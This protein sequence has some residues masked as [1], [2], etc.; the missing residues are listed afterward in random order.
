MS[1]DVLPPLREDLSLLR[2][3]VSD[4]APTWTLYDPARHRFIRMNWQDFEIFS[5]WALRTPA[6]ILAALQRETTL[7]LREVDVLRLAVFAREAGLLRAATP[8][9]SANLVAARTAAKRSAAAWL[10]HNYL[11]L[12]IRL[13]N[14][15]RFLTAMMP[16]VRWMYTAAYLVALGFLALFGLFLIS[17]QWDLYTHSLVE[18][19]TLDGLLWMGVA[20]SATKVIHE[21]AHGFAAK[22][23]GCRVPSMGVAFLVMWPVLWT[24]T[25]DAWR[26]RE[27]RQRLV[28]DAAGVLGEINVAALASIVWAVLPDGPARSAA[29]MLSSSTWILTLFINISPLMRFDGYY[30]LSDALGVANLQERAFAYARWMV[31]EALFRPGVAPPERFRPAMARTLLIYSLCS[32]TYRFL[33]FT[34]I[35]VLVYHVAFK[36]LGFVLMAVELWFFV[37]RPILRELGVW[38]RIVGVSRPNAHM[39]ASLVLL[40]VVLAGVLV[41]WRGRVDAPGLLRAARQVTLYTNEPGRLIVVP[42]LGQSF[43]EGQVVFTLDSP[44]V[45]HELKVAAADLEAAQA[46]LTARN[47]DVERQRSQPASLAAASEA[48]AALA[49]AEARAA[50]LEVRAPFGGLLTDIPPGLRQG[51]D[52]RRLEPLGVLIDPV[53]AVVEAYVAEVDLQRLK[54]GAPAHFVLPGGATLTL[55]LQAIAHA[56]TRVLE[57]QELA[58][59]HGGPIAVRRDQKGELSPE[60]AVYRVLLAVDG[61]AP[62][63]RREVGYVAIEA[64]AESVAQVLYRRMVAL[65]RREASL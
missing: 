34:G 35:A 46:D 47:F 49:H 16:L 58:S 37:A 52:L 17:R 54:E 22:R 21:L 27:R 13:V 62:V 31:R 2:G 20:L 28:I 1:E 56:S 6:A 33:L 43:R 53:D 24:D 39:L 14:P 59:V 60:R 50:D 42:D 12:R 61:G 9:D 8:R 32:W 57:P 38:V 5:R 18:N 45:T 41:P 29:F 7:R 10:V 44:E 23:F 48:A 65:V 26:I 25:T 3:P 64:P 30:L 11:F 36:T 55:R 40:L 51:T 19:F 4:G 63:L 15:D